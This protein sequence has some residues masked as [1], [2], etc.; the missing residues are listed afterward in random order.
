VGGARAGWDYSPFLGVV[1][2]WE[3]GVGGYFP[4]CLFEGAAR[5]QSGLCWGGVVDRQLGGGGAGVWACAGAHVLWVFSGWSL[6]GGWW[7][8]F[9]W[10]GAPPL[11]FG[12]DCEGG[13]RLG[14]VLGGGGGVVVGGGGG[15]GGRESESRLPPFCGGGVGGVVGGSVLFGGGVGWGGS[16][17]FFLGGGQGPLF[18]GVVFCLCVLWCGRGSVSFGVLCRVGWG[19]GGRVFGAG[20]LL[21]FLGG[22]G[23]LSLGG[24]VGCE[25]SS[26][27]GGGGGGGVWD[28]LS[29]GVFWEGRGRFGVGLFLGQMRRVAAANVGGGVGVVAQSLGVWGWGGGGGGRGPVE[30]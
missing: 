1:L 26:S 2:A 17:P 21:S 15:G 3:W 22:G 19:S 24:G 29:P 4:F 9:V 6:L 11:F 16:R 27:G 25:S 12:G 14:G 10:C 18:C 28:S 13:W 23:Q 8:R 30:A 7:A 20:P 5:V